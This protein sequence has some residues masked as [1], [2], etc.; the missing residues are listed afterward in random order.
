MPR[1]VPPALAKLGITRIESNLQP[2]Q[3]VDFSQAF[4]RIFRPEIEAHFSKRKERGDGDNDA[5]ERA[6]GAGA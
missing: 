5:G 2:G 4:L 6:G 3:A 1:P